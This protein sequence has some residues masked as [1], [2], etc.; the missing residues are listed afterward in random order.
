MTIDR[1]LGVPVWRQLVSIFR[2]RIESNEW[3]SG[4]LLP[5][6]RTLAQQY[7]VAE[8][9]IKKALGQLKADGL[10][11]STVGRGWYVL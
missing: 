9:T 2:G 8:L 3:E 11:D 1:G 4:R 10:V 5:S 6:V 7:E